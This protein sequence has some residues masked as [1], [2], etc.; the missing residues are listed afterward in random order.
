MQDELYFDTYFDTLTGIDE[1]RGILG[2]P[3]ILARAYEIHYIDVA[4][5]NLLF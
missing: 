2:C 4:S 3:D 1:K 5:Y